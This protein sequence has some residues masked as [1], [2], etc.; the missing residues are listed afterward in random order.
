M[1]TQGKTFN[2]NI[3]L[4]FLIWQKLDLALCKEKWEANCK[5]YINTVENVL[6]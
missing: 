5:F 1:N 2:C 6:Y 3:Q 4:G